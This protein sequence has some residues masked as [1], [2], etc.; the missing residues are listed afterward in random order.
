MGVCPMASAAPAQ[1]TAQNT[2]HNLP[3]DVGAD[4]ARRR[5]RFRLPDARQPVRD[6]ALQVGQVDAIAVRP[7]GG[8]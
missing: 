5:L 4:A 7:A 3:P 2:P 6:L 1:K 8:S